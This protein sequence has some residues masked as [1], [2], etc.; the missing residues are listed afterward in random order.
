[1]KKSE[2]FAI[3]AKEIKSL[4]FRVFVNV[5]KPGELPY[6][7]GYFS[8]GANVGSFQLGDFGGVRWS[9][10]NKYGSFCSGFSCVDDG[11]PVESLTAEKLRTAFCV[12]PSWYRMREIDRQRGGVKK[13]A[14]LD[15]FLNASFIGGVTNRDRLQEI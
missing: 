15:E 12:V 7:Y 11:V 10:V 14:N 5:N 1:M 4:G 6:Y 2:Y 9:S 3:A 8:D 13:F